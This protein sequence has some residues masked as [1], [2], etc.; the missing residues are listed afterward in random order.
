MAEKEDNNNGEQEGSHGAVPA[1]TLGDA[2]M[3][4]GGPEQ[5]KIFVLFL[6]LSSCICILWSNK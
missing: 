6:K 2:V 3:D 1:V 4:H 5:R